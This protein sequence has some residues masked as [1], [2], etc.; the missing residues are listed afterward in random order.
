MDQVLSKMM[1]DRFGTIEAD[2]FSP[3]NIG[4]IGD[5]KAIK[6][7]VTGLGA[8]KYAMKNRE[9]SI[10]PDDVDEVEKV[11][12]HVLVMRTGKML[13][14]GRVDELTSGF[15]FIEMDS[16]KNEEVKAQ[17]ASYNGIS[18]LKE[19]DGKLIALLSEDI[20]A[21][22]VNSYLHSKGISL[23]H[24]NK[25]RPNLEDQFLELVKQN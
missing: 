13:Y 17:L 11:C 3:G 5:E 21:S 1:K 14:S 25:S 22:E 12:S 8:L 24:I 2:F 20:S 4:D 19:E 18:E 23:N 10:N 9:K 7:Y 16:D 6:F 15:G